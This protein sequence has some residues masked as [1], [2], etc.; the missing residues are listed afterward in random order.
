MNFKRPCWTALFITLGMAVLGFFGFR[1]TKWVGKGPETWWETLTGAG[2]YFLMIFGAFGS[3]VFLIW[4]L[5]D[6]LRSRN[7][8]DHPKS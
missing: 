8:S 6:A 7:H 5:V 1:T 3:V 2:S 4:C